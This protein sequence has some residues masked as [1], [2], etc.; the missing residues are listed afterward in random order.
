MAD[1]RQ[2]SSKSSL[3]IVQTSLLTSRNKSSRRLHLG[4]RIYGSGFFRNRQRQYESHDAVGHD[5]QVPRSSMMG[6]RVITE[7]AFSNT[8]SFE[9]SWRTVTSPVGSPIVT[10]G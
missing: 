4:S 5:R 6:R 3:I 8:S 10:V 1:N 7:I 2:R 9:T